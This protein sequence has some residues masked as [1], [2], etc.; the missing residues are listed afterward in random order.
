M[1]RAIPG[2]SDLRV[3]FAWAGA[4]D[5]TPDL[6]PVI[7]D[8]SELPGFYLATGFSGHGFA[9]GPAAGELVADMVTGA[10]PSIDISPYRLGRFT[11]GSSL[12]VPEMM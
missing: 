3:V 1:K 4:I 8:V 2:F 7:S 11:D 5:T 12:K 10:K 9:L 6:I